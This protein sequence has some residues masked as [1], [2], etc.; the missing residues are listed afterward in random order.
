MKIW[1]ITVHVVVSLR[2]CRRTTLTQQ[3]QQEKSPL[4]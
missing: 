2:P 1:H 4:P 3:H